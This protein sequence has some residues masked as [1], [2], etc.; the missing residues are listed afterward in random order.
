MVSIKDSV[1]LSGGLH[2]GSSMKPYR[3]RYV[4][5]GSTL[6]L[7][8]PQAQ[9]RA[10]V[11]KECPASLYI[12]LLQ[13]RYRHPQFPHLCSIM[14]AELKG[15]FDGGSLRTLSSRNPWKYRRFDEKLTGERSPSSTVL[16]CQ[17]SRKDFSSRTCTC[18][19][20]SPS[21][22]R[23]SKWGAPERVCNSSLFPENFQN[24]G[25]PKLGVPF[26]GSPY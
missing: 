11:L 19:P 17:D 16:L 3:R 7:S 14:V 5:G 13:P 2:W 10:P 15:I 1:E 20:S 8:S 26:G 12:L 23:A 24:G 6:G 22:P 9:T 25:F 4:L 18:G 21:R